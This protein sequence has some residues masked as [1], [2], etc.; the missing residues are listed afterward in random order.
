VKRK[1]AR[2]KKPVVAAQTLSRPPLERMMRIHDAI[3]SG[4]YPNAARLAKE[5]EVSQKSVQRDLEFMRER[6]NFPIEYDQAKWGFYYTKEVGSFPAFTVTEGELF[7]VL[8][9]EK[10]MHQYR[11]TNLERPL[12][13]AFKKLAASL[14]ET[15]SLHMADWEQTISFRSSAEP[16]S[17]LEVFDQLARAAAEGRQ[18]ALQYRKPG[19]AAAENRAVDPYHLANVNGDWF[20]FAYCHLRK[21]IRTF[22]PARIVSAA[23]TGKRFQRPKNFSIENALRDSF[24]VHSGKAEHR[25]VIRFNELVADYIREKKW[26]ASQELKNLSNGGVELSLRL[27]SLVE[28]QRWILSWAGNAE[29]IAPPELKKAVQQAGARIVAMS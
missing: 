19:S 18:L 3:Q 22:A 24:G 17:N 13:S 8:V 1:K 11:G 9:A 28:V 14:P 6:M 2:M 23:A 10:A 29:V 7:S 16:I 25:V 5:L 26:H 4:K 27:S 15:I 20:L 12:M 21:D